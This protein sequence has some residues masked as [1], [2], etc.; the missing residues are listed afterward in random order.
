MVKINFRFI[1][2][3]WLFILYSCAV[4][5]AQPTPKK[6]DSLLSVAK[7]MTNVDS[8]NTLIEEVIRKSK[9]INYTKGLISGVMTKGVN[10]FNIGRFEESLKLTHDWEKVIVENGDDAK[11]AHLYALRGNSFGQLLFFKEAQA[12]LL[13]SLYYGNKIADSNTRYYNLGRTYGIIANNI[14]KNTSVPVDLDSVL[15]YR[16]KAYQNSKKLLET[17]LSSIFCC[18]R[19]M[20]LRMPIL[21]REC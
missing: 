19:A 21:R 16:K 13:K 7:R 12:S 10:L 11:L 14:Q 4:T 18:F 3:G 20:E 2:F 1:F 15:F 5:W 8:S 6:I 17:G 9:Q